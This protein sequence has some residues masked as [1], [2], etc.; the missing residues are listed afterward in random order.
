MLQYQIHKK[1][2]LDGS[3]PSAAYFSKP[4]KSV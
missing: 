1:V 4:L 2:M 3:F